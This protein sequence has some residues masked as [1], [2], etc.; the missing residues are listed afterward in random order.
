MAYRESGSLEGAQPS[1]LTAKRQ[2]SILVPDARRS[3][4]KPLGRIVSAALTCAVLVGV[5]VRF[6][7]RPV[8]TWVHAHLGDTRFDWFKAHYDGHLLSIGPFGLMAGPSQALGPVAVLVLAI[9][10][11]AGAAGW[12]PKMR[13]RIIV[14]LTMSVFAAMQINSIVKTVFGRTWPES[15]LGSNPSWIRDGVFGFFPLSRRSR[16]GLLPVRPHDGHHDAGHDPVGC[17]A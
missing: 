1:G 2:P 4:R 6:I 8:A 13:G 12:R 7:D 17:V 9:L 3:F 15:W 16:L 11:V 14:A 10:A 5:S